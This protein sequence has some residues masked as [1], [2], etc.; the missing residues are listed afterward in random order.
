[1]L[2][3]IIRLIKTQFIGLPVKNWRSLNFPRSSFI[4]PFM[5]F[6]NSSTSAVLPLSSV[7]DDLRHVVLQVD[8]VVLLAAEAG[9]DQPV[10]QNKVNSTLRTWLIS[11]SSFLSRGIGPSQLNVI[12][13]SAFR[14]P[15]PTS[16]GRYSSG[17]I[18][19][20]HPAKA[21]NKV[22]CMASVRAGPPK[23]NLVIEFIVNSK[24]RINSVG[25]SFCNHWSLC[26]CKKVCHH[27]EMKEI[28]VYLLSNFC[29]L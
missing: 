17:T 29:T 1:M 13:C 25:R 16:W 5:F 23:P 8:G 2:W 24:Y 21:T 19:K 4:T 18:F 3:T 15:R 7:L 22:F 26:W 11:L 28:N 27:L 12:R 6:L 10:V 9:F 14:T 20:I